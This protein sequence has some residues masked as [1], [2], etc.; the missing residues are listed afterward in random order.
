[1]KLE[2]KIQECGLPGNPHDWSKPRITGEHKSSRH[3][4][5]CGRRKEIE[6]IPDT[7]KQE[8]RYLP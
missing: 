5:L 1:M 4:A 7:G 6:F 3:C 2:L 8:T